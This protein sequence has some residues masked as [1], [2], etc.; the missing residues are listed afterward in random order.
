M[1]RLLALVGKQEKNVRSLLFC[2][3][4]FV[5]C[6]ENANSLFFSKELMP[7]DF[8]PSEEGAFVS[9][10]HQKSNSVSLV[11]TQRHSLIFDG[12]LFNRKAL[13]GKIPTDCQLTDTE[14][15]AELILALF[16]NQGTTIFADL[17]GYWSLIILD[18]DK[19]QL[20]AARDHFG[21]RPL[22]YCNTENC[23]GISSR[24][25]F[26]HNIDEN[27]KE[28]NKNA[29]ADY[30]LWGDIV[31]HS[32]TFFV[33]IHSLPSAHY[34]LYSFDNQTVET[35]SYY[36]LPYKRCKAG[37]NEYEEPLYIDNVRQFVL[38]SVRENIGNQSRMALGI[39]GGLDSSAILCSALKVNP[40]CKYT[41]F[42]FVNQYDKRDNFWAEKIIRHT[43]VDWV[44][45]PCH[46][47]EIVEILPHLNKIQDVPIFVTG[48]FAQYKVMQAVK[49]QGFETILDGQGGNELFGGYT[50]YFPPFW[51]AL[52][53][54]WQIKDLLAE[55]FY[56]KNAGIGY[57]DALLLL[58]NVAKKHYFTK[59]KL[60]K[61]TKPQELRFLNKELTNDYF[62]FSN[63]N[64]MH[65]EV[66]NDC[67]FESYT[68]FLTNILRWGESSAGSFGLDCLMPFANSKKMAEYVFS[69]PS[70]FKIHKSWGKYLLRS[71]MVGIVPDEIR[72]RRQKI[73]FE[74]PEYHWF[75]EIGDEIKQQIFAL[76]DSAN[77]VDKKQL[78]DQWN[79]LY[80][81]QNFHFQQFVFRYYSYLTWRAEVG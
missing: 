44:K 74:A 27:A 25:R 71:A 43:A 45:V 29:V 4:Q 64:E 37:Y 5:R 21:N 47:K 51:N 62:R 60:A 50:A 42:T 54:Q 78:L 24:S 31:K 77:F 56:L 55:W 22:F 52:L 17:E 38:D 36:E 15:D 40:D 39:S 20:I 9:V 14:N 30:L 16:T 59:E 1:S 65:K 73:G 79:N 13:L 28:I 41:A 32:Q 67:L 6:N 11:Q 33:N 35:N 53:S 66:L 2:L 26:L 69:L 63:Q 49:E 10:L 12:K 75:Q 34:L 19:K 18:K 7:L 80:H 23:F 58:K 57:K 70:T 8:C 3:Q 76:N 81:P 61:R 48:T 68:H 46:A 72:W